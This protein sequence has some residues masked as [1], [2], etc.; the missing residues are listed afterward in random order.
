M[1][2]REVDRIPEAASVLAQR[3]PDRFLVASER[4]IALAHPEDLALP[5]VSQALFSMRD[6]ADLSRRS[7]RVS[8]VA[9]LHEEH[10]SAPAVR[11]RVRAL[12]QVPRDVSDG[13]FHSSAPTARTSASSSSSPTFTPFLVDQWARRRSIPS[14]GGPMMSSV[15]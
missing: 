14:V 2:K 4:P 5:A 13:L 11:R 10:G 6:V 15:A 9:R 7:A 12:G 3:L 1:M 8:V